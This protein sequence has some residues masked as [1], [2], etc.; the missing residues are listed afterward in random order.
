VLRCREGDGRLAR[1]QG[2][3]VRAG[4]RDGV[5]DRAAV[6]D[7]DVLLD[8]GTG[9]GLIGFGALERVGPSGRVIF[10]D[11]S[12]DLLDECRR[13]AADEGVLDRCR[14]VSAGADDLAG[15]EDASVDV[16][17]TRSV[18]IYVARK[19]AAFAE[20]FR[21]LRPGG[22]LSIFEPINRFG[23]EDAGRT[24]YGLDTTA[25]ADLAEK[26][27]RAYETVPVDQDPML[28]FDERDLLRWAAG[29]GFEALELDYRAEVAVPQPQLTGDW[30][31]LRKTAPNPLAPTLDEAMARTLTVAER[32][33][34]SDHA[35]AVLASGA[36]LRRTI[37][38]A[39]L[40]GVRP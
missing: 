3:S 9:D 5:L 16:V 17:T 40:R 28:N 37:A 35:R 26:V 13:R 32:E 10:S 1:E 11:I 24:L 7:G 4:F 36:P 18:L 23:I 29:A 33:R 30:Q 19:E 39:Y 8:V 12:A 38:T 15:V 22:R 27:R 31:V 6:T 14:F 2:V 20:F 21:V 25:I 34:F